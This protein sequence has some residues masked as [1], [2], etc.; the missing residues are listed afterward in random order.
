MR[1][2]LPAVD[3]FNSDSWSD[4]SGQHPAAEPMY[5]PSR[6]EDGRV[7]IPPLVKWGS[8]KYGHHESLDS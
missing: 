3:R 2:G 5:E 8:L 4:G 1:L 6:H 7:G